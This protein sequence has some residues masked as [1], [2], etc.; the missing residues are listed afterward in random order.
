MA[1]VQAAFG[2][3][4]SQRESAKCLLQLKQGKLTAAEYAIEFRTLATEAGW[5][6][7]SLMTTFYHGLQDDLKDA[8]V[9]RDWGHSLEELI[10]LTSE[11]DQRTRERRRERLSNAQFPVP[12]QKA[13]STRQSHDTEES[14]QL[15]RSRLSL[16]ERERRRRENLC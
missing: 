8:L 11:L 5:N 15:G 9:N 1:Q 3:P 10:A 6:G 16:E 4:T 7:N 13:Q 14:M 12:I 2:H